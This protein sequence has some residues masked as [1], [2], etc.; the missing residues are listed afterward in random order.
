MTITERSSK[1]DIIDSSMEII[2][3][4]DDTIANLRDDRRALIVLASVA[5]I[6]GVLF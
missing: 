3:T 5:V 2:S 1:Q 6:W 4:Q